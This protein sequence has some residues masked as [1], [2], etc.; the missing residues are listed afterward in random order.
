[1]GAKDLKV[2]LRKV[3]ESIPLSM[4]TS[5]W[6]SHVDQH[7]CEIEQVISNHVQRIEYRAQ[8]AE[9]DAL[10]SKIASRTQHFESTADR[11]SQSVGEGGGDAM[12]ARRLVIQQY[13]DG[14]EMF[15]EELF[16]TTYH[17]LTTGQ[18]NGQEN[19]TEAET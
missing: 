8:R 15:D 13:E 19:Q 11:V 16:S 18:T 5:N 3:A 9:R 6:L 17:A 12:L 1:M 2:R 14:L 7:I 4:D 10:S